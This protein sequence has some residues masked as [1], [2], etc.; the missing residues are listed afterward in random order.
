[1]FCANCGKELTPGA[2]FCA[3]CGHATASDAPAPVA[4]P[5]APAAN[6]PAA[7]SG[8][9]LGWLRGMKTWKKVVLGIVLFIFGVIALAMYA[10]S[11]LDEPVKRHFAALHSGDIV[12]AYSELSV[13]ARQTT[14]LDAFKTMLADSPGLTHV[15]GESFSSRSYANSQGLLEGMLEIEGGGKIPIEVNLVKE[16]GAWKILNYHVTAA[17]PAQ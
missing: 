8:G 16:N 12:G 9:F 4:A 15:T 3:A 13:A 1:M 6:P 17:K 11:G 7:R 10:T 2:Q 5:S 14:S